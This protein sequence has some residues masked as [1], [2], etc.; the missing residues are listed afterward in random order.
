M[1][2]NRSNR[3][4]PH[5]VI[6]QRVGNPVDLALIQNLNE[7]FDTTNASNDKLEYL[8]SIKHVLSI[9]LHEHCSSYATFI[10]NRSFFTL[11]NESSHG[12]WDLGS[13]KAMWRGFYSCLVFAKGRNQ[14][15]M[16][17]DGKFQHK[18]KN[19]QLKGYSCSL[20]YHIV[21]HTVFTKKQPFLDFLCE[22]MLHSPCGKRK[23]GR[24]RDVQKVDGNDVLRFLD[25]N[26]AT[27]RGEVDFLLKQCKRKY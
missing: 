4:E 2:P 1:G 9:V 13:G 12:V 27:Y 14:L 18:T 20:Q 21:K 6:I 5:K 3:Q 16:N 22:V 10:Y 15:L 24:Q 17:L 8:Q 19:S 26:T 25:I 23:Y 7:L 11:A